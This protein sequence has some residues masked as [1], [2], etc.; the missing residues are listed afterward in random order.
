M[1]IAEK[2]GGIKN[3]QKPITLSWT[4]TV[5]TRRPKIL[6]LSGETFAQAVLM[7]SQEENEND[8]H[9]ET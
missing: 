8:M 2:V 3:V 9:Y 7:L 1:E 6:L 5:R 4:Y